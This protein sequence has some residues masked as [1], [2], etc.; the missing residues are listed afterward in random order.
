[1][2]SSTGAIGRATR[3]SARF[4]CE[5]SWRNDSGHAPVNEIKGTLSEGTSAAGFV[6]GTGWLAG[7]ALGAELFF[8]AGI[9][10]EDSRLRKAAETGIDVGSSTTGVSATGAAGGGTTEAGFAGTTGTR[11]T[12]F[13]GG[14]AG[15]AGA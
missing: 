8:G 1:M 9:P 11:G 14:V 6:G 15:A 5:I 13:T 2:A 7:V 12:G 4:N 10:I 3:A